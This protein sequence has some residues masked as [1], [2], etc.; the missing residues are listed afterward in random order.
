MEKNKWYYCKKIRASNW[1]WKHSNK[2]LHRFN[3]NPWSS[4]LFSRHRTFVWTENMSQGKEKT[5][6]RCVSMNIIL[7]LWS[8]LSMRS[9]T[10]SIPF[11]SSSYSAWQR[12]RKIKGKVFIFVHF[13]RVIWS[14]FRA[15][16]RYKNISLQ[17]FFL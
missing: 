6:V 1:K 8:H 2:N 11:W 17:T 9:W 12:E 16:I 7:Y 13:Y 14:H 15:V 10:V 5:T 3:Q 4:D